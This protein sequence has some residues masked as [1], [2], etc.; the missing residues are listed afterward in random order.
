MPQ[1]DS[2]GISLNYTDSGGTGRPVVLIHG[3]PLSGASW[4]EQVPA[5]TEAGHRV[6]TYDRRGFGDSEKPADGYDYDTF[7]ADL[8]GLVDGLD[9][10]DVTLVGFSMGGGEIARYVGRYGEK[11][12]HSVAFAGAV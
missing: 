8:A 1:I 7:A 11:R 6:I 12:L 5:L 9:L 4:S 3:W 10:Q 2:N